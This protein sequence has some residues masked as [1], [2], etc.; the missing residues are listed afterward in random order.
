MEILASFA[1][2]Y[3][4]HAVL[5]TLVTV[6]LAACGGDEV[7]NAT[8]SADA[9]ARTS[10]VG[11]ASVTSSSSTTSQAAGVTASAD[12]LTA[13]ATLPAA[14][15]IATGSVNR[16]PISSP[17]PVSEPGTVTKPTSP[18]ST[19]VSNPVS[20]PTPAPTPTPTPTPSSGTVTVDWMPPTE[21]TDGSVLT[22]LAGYEI[23]YGTDPNNLTKS[24]KVTN[25]G[26]TAYTMSDLA[27]GTWYFAI[28]ALSST[29]AE[30]TRTQMISTK[31]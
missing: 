16:G 13:A 11:A 8:D 6:G 3:V 17:S 7:S 15:G 22:N 4:R 26:L 18:I 1:R 23:Y 28:A 9:V 20:T 24:V 14:S 12:A 27:S 10:T 2:T 25:A 21:N 19:P 30:S 31:L 5:L 29:G